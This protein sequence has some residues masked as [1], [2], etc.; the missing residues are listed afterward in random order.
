MERAVPGCTPGQYI[1]ARE[2]ES[3]RKSI[4]HGSSTRSTRAP[5][6]GW[7]GYTRRGF[8]HRHELQPPPR[9]SAIRGMSRCRRLPSRLVSYASAPEFGELLGKGSA[10]IVT[11]S[12]GGPTRRRIHH[13]DAECV[14]RVAI[15]EDRRDSA[16]ACRVGAR[17]ARRLRDRLSSSCGLARPTGWRIPG[18]MTVMMP[19]R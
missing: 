1:M 19:G 2:I 3:W 4:T 10:L 6:H 8:D 17:I 16:A 11:G 18:R 13:I 14:A 7:A 12:S 15:R 5:V 9:P